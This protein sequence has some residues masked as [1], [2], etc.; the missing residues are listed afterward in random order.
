MFDLYN[1]F[2]YSDSKLNKD[3]AEKATQLMNENFAAS[4]LVIEL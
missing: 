3:L 4:K 1:L 2:R